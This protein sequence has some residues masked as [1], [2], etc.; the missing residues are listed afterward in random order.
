MRSLG[1]V[2]Y[3]FHWVVQGELARSA[4]AYAGFLGAFLKRHGI[5]AVLNL[6]GPNPRWRWWHYEKRVCERIGIAHIDLAINSRNLILRLQLERMLEIAE[7]A[8]KPLLVKCSGGQDRTSFVCALLLLH[9]NGWNAF[10]A[11]LAQFDRWPYLHMP[12]PQQRWLKQFFFFA[13]EQAQ[14]SRLRDWISS[15]YTP[16]DF[17]A[18][19]DKRGMS[20]FYSKLYTTPPRGLR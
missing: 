19:L 3:N 6:R 20:G 10:D 8:P 16:E 18:W 17:K 9:E 5:R 11:A 14:G 13:R 7:S 4:Q 2:L 1:D 15:G 12:K